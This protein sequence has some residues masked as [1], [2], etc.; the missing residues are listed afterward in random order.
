MYRKTY[1]CINLDAIKYN[2]NNALK[3]SKK[4][5]GFAV[6]K[7]NGYGHGA[8]DVAKAAI[9]GGATHLAVATFEEALELRKEFNKVP[10]LVLGYTDFK[11]FTVAS[12]YA[13]TVTLTNMYQ[14]EKL[15]NYNEPLKIHIK[16]N[17][18]MNRLG[19]SN[20][21]DV[22][23]AYALIRY[24]TNLAVEGLF[25]HFSTADMMDIGF[26][27]KQFEMFETIVDDIG[28]FFKII[29]C[30]NSAATLYPLEGM[31]KCNAFR[32]GIAMYGYNPSDEKI[33]DF[34]LSEAFSLYSEV[35]SV[36]PVRKGGKVGY[37][38]TYALKKDGYI[39][40]IPIGYADGII[41]A[42]SSREV[43]INNKRFPIVGR[44]CMDQLMILVDESVKIG[45]VV[46]LI[47]KNIT[48][49]EVSK[50][51]NTIDYEV[52]C[53]ISDRVTRV[54]FENSKEVHEKCFRYI[55]N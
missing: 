7:A 23:K 35:S 42:N 13:I 1:A 27:K 55:L 25:T 15:A 32:F 49:S 3:L 47:G 22:R 41:R 37:G 10:I 52:L 54:Y 50:H 11:Y 34:E 16:V 12:K 14:A 45:D 24:N 5:Y 21:E 33:P 28:K 26:Y 36:I 9:K 48:M 39:A 20:L 17:T 2:F 19:F 40:T 29:H 4:E 44:V 6:V 51:L 8:V 43:M 31:N 18:G 53:S 38:A 30:Q 46:E